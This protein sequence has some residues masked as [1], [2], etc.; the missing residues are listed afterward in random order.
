MRP[1]LC[2]VSMLLPLFL[3]TNCADSFDDVCHDVDVYLDEK[4]EVYFEGYWL[5]CPT[6]VITGA[7]NLCLFERGSLYIW[8]D[9]SLDES[10]A[11]IFKLKRVDEGV[12]AYKSGEDICDYVFSV[13]SYSANWLSVFVVYNDEKYISP[14]GV[15]MW[16]R[17]Q[18]DF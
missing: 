17:V 6:A 7:S 5:R 3:C 13:H 15:K 14:D 1:G 4:G 8:S 16:R 18:C 2:W 10:D 12:C 9:F 11:R